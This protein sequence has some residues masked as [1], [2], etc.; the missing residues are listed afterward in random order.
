MSNIG[1]LYTTGAGYIPS[2]EPEAHTPRAGDLRQFARAMRG[3]GEAR[4]TLPSVPRAALTLNAPA[5][6]GYMAPP[7]ELSD[8]VESSLASSVV[9]RLAEVRRV[10]SAQDYDWVSSNPGSGDA[11]LG[12][13][14]GESGSIP[15]NDPTFA[16]LRLGSY[17]FTSGKSLVPNELFEDAEPRA[18][19]A[20][21]TALTRRIARIQNKLFTVGIGGGQPQGVAR[22]ASVQV[23]V[24]AG[25]LSFDNIISLYSSLDTVW[26]ED[27]QNPP[28]WMMTPA[29]FAVLS[30]LKD[31]SGFNVN[32]LRGRTLMEC[33]IE[34]NPHLDAVGAGN[35]PILFGRFDQYKIRDRDNLRFV[36]VQELS[37]TIENWSSLVWAALRS[38]G[39]LLIADASLPPVV[40]LSTT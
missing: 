25:S 40:A 16:Q 4:V 28:R 30:K 31:V 17:K 2:P 32:L 20:L 33:R 38:D 19:P 34:F 15:T 21:M 9:R 22:G 5:G 29:T 39:G 27:P 3:T 36:R 7:A 10:G 35:T 26:H 18:W 6:G 23:T 24:A 12:Q 37:G 14:V 8:V 1:T 13:I 11:G